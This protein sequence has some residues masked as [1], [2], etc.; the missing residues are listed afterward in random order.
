MKRIRIATIILFFALLLLPLLKFSFGENIVSEIDNRV[1]AEN[2][3]GKNTE[4]DW[5]KGISGMLEEY[6]SDRIGFR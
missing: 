3:F 4:I 6:V 5:E 1:L 2:P